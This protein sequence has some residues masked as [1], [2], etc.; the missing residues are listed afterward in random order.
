MLG[1]S[2][3]DVIHL[4]RGGRYVRTSAG[5]IQFGVPPETIKDSIALGLPVPTIY[6]LPRELF[7]KSRGLNVSECEFPAYYNFFI[8]KRRIRLVV[9]GPAVEARVRTVFSESLFGPE[10]KST[11]GEF[12]PD[13]PAALRPDFEKEGGYFRRGPDGK[14]LELDA[15][16]EFV[17]FDE[18]GAA[19]VAPGVVVTQQSDGGYTVHDGGARLA[20]VPPNVGLPERRSMLP[21]PAQPFSPPEFGV[22]VLGASHGFDPAGKTTGIIVWIGHRGLLVDPPVDTTYALREH[23]IAPKLIEGIILTHC[24]ADHDSGTF[25]KLLEEGRV[26]VYTTPTILG[27]F[28][29][30]YAALSGIALGLLRRTFVFNPVQIGAPTRVHGADLWFF[31]TLHSIP[32]LGFEV[33]YGGRSLAFSGDSL[34]DPARIYAMRDTGV[35]SRER[36]DDLIDFPWHHTVVLHEAGVPPLHTPASV[37]ATLPAEIKER[38]YLVH[39]A[40]KD[41]PQNAGLK[42]ARVGLEHTIR[43]D[44]PPPPHAEALEILDAFSAVELFRGFTVT[45]AREILRA[46]RVVRVGPDH[47]IIEQGADGDSF[48]V[49]ASGRVSVRRDGVEI[50]VYQAGDYFGETAL[51]FDEPRNADVVSLA[52]TTLLAFDRYDFLYLVRHT[53]I[54]ARLVRLARMRA[55]RSWEVFDKNSILRRLTSAQKTQLQTYLVS[56]PVHRGEVLWRAG[57]PAEEAFLLDEGTVT[58]EGPYE[59]LAP[60]SSGAFVGEFDAIQQGQRHATTARAREDGRVFRIGRADLCRFLEENPA[61]LVALIGTRFV[62]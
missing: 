32:A 19:T 57:S 8:L 43:I 10:K 21:L 47:R 28:L 33:F 45:Q 61:A 18:R 44:V 54:A 37:L 50:K 14:R 12:A 2:D 20:L 13:C 34:Y 25:Q 62:E 42:V 7:D 6:V 38:L 11:P 53:D 29:K 4:P 22:T 36:C 51:L 48:Y 41:V 60:F 40:D 46:T 5:A 1:V 27:S 56:R 58:L 30:K 59:P 24:H 23:G 52:E 39:I 17:H 35:L 16:V 26:S 9:E 31:Y 3:E 15:L 55:E 49:I